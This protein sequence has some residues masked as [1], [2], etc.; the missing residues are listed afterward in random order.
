LQYS[1]LKADIYLYFPFDL[2][3]SPLKIMRCMREF[4]I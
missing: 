2:S 4:L 1:L 3:P